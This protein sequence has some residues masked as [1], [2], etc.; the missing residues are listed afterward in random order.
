M[1]RLLLQTGLL[2]LKEIASSQ[3]TVADG[4]K[5]TVK[6]STRSKRPKAANAE[7]MQKTHETNAVFKEQ[8]APME[9]CY[10]L[11]RK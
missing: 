5:C 10:I 6:A 11:E 4:D 3:T 8:D 9:E 1:R 7:A 2:I